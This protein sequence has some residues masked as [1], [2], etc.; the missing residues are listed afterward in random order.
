MRIPVLANLLAL[1]CVGAPPAVEAPQPNVILIMTDDQGYGDFGVLGNPTIRTPHLDALAAQSAWLTTFYV[2]PVCAPTR[3]SLM[4]GRYNYRTRAIDTY[5]GRAMME[6]EEVT[7]AE[8][9][10]EAGWATGIFGKWHLGDCYPMRAVDQGFERS[11]VHRGGG[12]GQPSDPPEGERKYTDAVLFEDGREVQ[13]EGYCTDVY[14]DA[15]MEWLEGAHEAGRPFFAYIAP[16]APHGPFHDVP[17]ELYREYLAEDLSNAAAPHAAGHPLPEHNDEDRRARIFAMITNIDQNVGRLCA[18]LDEL[19]LAEDTLV[20]F[21]VDNGP[22]ERRYT[23]N[24]R[25]NKGSVYEGGVRSPLFARW[26][27]RLEAGNRSDRISA[28]IDVLPTILEACSVTPPEDLHLD[29]RSFLP[30][31][32]GMPAPEAERALVIQAHRGD[33]PV[34][35]HH[36]FLRQGRWKLVAA[37]GFG[38]ETLP[39]QPRLELFDLEADPFELH[40]LAPEHPGVV[41][42]LS[43][44]YERWFEDVGSTR[45]DNY[46]PPPIHIGNARADP[47]VLTRQDWRRIGGGGGWGKDALGNWEVLV[48]R[49]GRFTVEARFNETAEAGTIELSV[50]GETRRAALARGARSWT[51][52]DLVLPAGPARLAVSLSYNDRTVG[53]HQVVVH[54]EADEPVSPR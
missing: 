13:T 35:Y 48:A 25:G 38:R 53:P 54:F 26:P 8:L 14:F 24:L 40:D 42:R 3:A 7:I 49:P 47:V 27:G 34:L 28:H 37:T 22:N 15:A 30:C 1:A 36:F 52:E 32:E 50:A 20:L 9:L 23:A 45:E 21:L 11:L 39:A 46:A 5:I 16:N 6:P 19:D 43:L 10:G 2:S 12:I 4:T 41:E 29:G 31:L 18:R 44:A 33:A 17:E 51:V